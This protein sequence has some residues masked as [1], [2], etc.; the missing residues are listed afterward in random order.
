M[1]TDEVMAQLFL[2][3]DDL[4]DSIYHGTYTVAAMRERGDPAWRD[5]AT[6]LR[7]QRKALRQL[8]QETDA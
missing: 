3:L 6:D 4:R 8:K 5:L 2:R 7:R 1:T